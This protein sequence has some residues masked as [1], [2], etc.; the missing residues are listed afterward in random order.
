MAQWFT[1]EDRHIL[2]EMYDSGASV[3]AIAEKLGRHYAT[4]YNELKK[5]Y[6][7]E[8]DKNGRPGYKAEIS[9]KR[10]Y[11]MKIKSFQTAN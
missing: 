2:E 5:G 3:N 6:T 9:Q 8:M 10:R 11:E 4:I 1:L 7:G